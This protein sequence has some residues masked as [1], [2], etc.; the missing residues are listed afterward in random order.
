MTESPITQPTASPATET[1]RAQETP[2]PAG[3]TIPS[4][5]KKEGT[6]MPEK[7]SHKKGAGK[8]TP[9]AMPKTVPAP[10]KPELKARGEQKPAAPK[11]SPKRE[12]G[13]KT[14]A[15]RLTEAESERIHKAA[16]PQRA[17]EFARAILLA[18]ASAITSG[19]TGKLTEALRAQAKEREAALVRAKERKAS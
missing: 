18:A 4:G 1:P 19:E 9:S 10:K 3:A 15:F 2:P 16:G 17:S 5:T 12:P 8:T 14:F 7:R 13:E 6:T 11:P